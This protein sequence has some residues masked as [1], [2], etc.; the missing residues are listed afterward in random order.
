MNEF[1]KTQ[2]HYVREYFKVIEN[3]DL[4]SKART[5]PKLKYDE[6]PG[7][8]DYIDLSAEGMEAINNFSPVVTVKELRGR[9]H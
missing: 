8:P 3:T 2:P 1:E 4:D 7:D 6:K 9:K 5:E